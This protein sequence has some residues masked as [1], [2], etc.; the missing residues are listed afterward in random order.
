MFDTLDLLP[1]IAGFLA[2][3]A[4]FTVLLLAG[5]ALNYAR[6]NPVGNMT[7]REEV[8]FVLW[9]NGVFASIGSVLFLIEDWCRC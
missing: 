3:M 7:L 2:I 1:K 4:G 9:F 8:R 5:L 6:K